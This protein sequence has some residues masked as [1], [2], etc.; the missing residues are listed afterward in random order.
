MDVKAQGDGV[1]SAV[2]TLT[3]SLEDL[4]EIVVKI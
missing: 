3:V 4:S 1:L 2:G